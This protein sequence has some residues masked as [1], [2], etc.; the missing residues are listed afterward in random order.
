MTQVEE[1]PSK[2]VFYRERS[3]RVPVL[4][5]LEGLPRQ[6]RRRCQ[7]AIERLRDN[8]H[9]LRHPHVHYLTKEIHEL[10]TRYGTNRYRIFYFWHGGNVAVLTGGIVKKTSAVPQSDLQR[11]LNR[12]LQFEQNPAIHTQEIDYAW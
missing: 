4:G 7:K 12:K 8:G 11:S 3:G 2:V 1:R 9:E 6:H 5:W 10:R